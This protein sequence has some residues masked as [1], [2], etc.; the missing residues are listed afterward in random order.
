MKDVL[1]TRY[2]LLPFLY[3]LFHRAHLQGDTVARPL[4][5]E[6][7]WDVATLGLD[8]QF[9][10][11]R[12]LLVTPV[13]EPGVDSV[14]GYVPRGVWYDFYTGSSVNSSGEMLKMSAPLEHLN[15]HVREGAILPTQKPGTTSEVTRGNPLRLI[16]ALSSSA[17]AWG[18]LFWDDGESLDTFERGSY[19]YLVF[20]VTQNIFTSTVLHA[21]TEATEVTIDTLSIFGVREPPSKVLLNGQEKPFSYLD[22]QVLTVS[23]LGLSLSQGFSLQWL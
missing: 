16:V 6:F 13:L 17:T 8:K 1:L 11:G 18:D 12:S 19:S 22:N 3:T 20:N 21:S 9:L 15:L 7:P 10:W 14:T 2:S 5:F 4:F 23:N